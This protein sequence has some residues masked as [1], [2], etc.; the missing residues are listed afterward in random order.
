[1]WDSQVTIRFNIVIV[2]WL[3]SFGV[4]PWLGKPPR[5]ICICYVY[6]YGYVYVYVFVFLHIYIHVHTYINIYCIYIYMCMY[7]SVYIYSI[8]IHTYIIYIRGFVWAGTHKR[9]ANLSG[10][11]VI[12][13]CAV[14][15]V[16]SCCALCSSCSAQTSNT[17]ACVLRL[18]RFWTLTSFRTLTSEP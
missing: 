12:S 8:Y 2:Q 13:A 15:V 16:C 17:F 7:I 18:H 11:E 3:W 1:M 10:F 9:S 4:P 6:A 14:A 5:S